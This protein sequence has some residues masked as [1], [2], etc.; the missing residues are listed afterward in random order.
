MKVASGDGLQMHKSLLPIQKFVRDPLH[1]SAQGCAPQIGMD[2]K[3]Q[4]A[5]NSGLLATIETQQAARF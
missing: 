5:A 4:L 3:A 1:N 2:C